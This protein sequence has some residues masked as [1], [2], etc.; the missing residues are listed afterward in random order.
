MKEGSDPLP[1]YFQ[2]YRCD[3]SCEDGYFSRVSF[4]L[5]REQVCSACG[6]NSIS[7]KNGFIVDAKMDDEYFLD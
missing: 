1:P 6:P 4:D 3:H 2:G 5:V 7:I